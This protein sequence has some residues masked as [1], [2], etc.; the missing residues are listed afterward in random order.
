M[1]FDI[2]F[3]IYTYLIKQFVLSKAFCTINYF[4]MKKIYIRKIRRTKT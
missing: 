3:N 2:I 4:N 1:S